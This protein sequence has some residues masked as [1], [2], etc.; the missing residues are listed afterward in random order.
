MIFIWWPGGLD[1]TQ[2][3]LFVFDP[4]HHLEIEVL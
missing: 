1:P 3:I 2:Q 4:T